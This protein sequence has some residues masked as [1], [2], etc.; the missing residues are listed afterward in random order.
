MKHKIGFDI[1][2]DISSVVVTQVWMIQDYFYGFNS[3]IYLDP[4]V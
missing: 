3:H 1:V 4:S 2:P